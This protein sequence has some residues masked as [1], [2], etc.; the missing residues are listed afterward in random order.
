V[1]ILVGVD[2][3]HDRVLGLGDSDGH[4]TPSWFQT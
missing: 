3:A 1:G 4:D 2:P